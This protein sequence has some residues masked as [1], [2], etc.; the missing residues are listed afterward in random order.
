MSEEYIRLP[1]T[2][3]T[4]LIKGREEYVSKKD[5]IIFLYKC[6]SESTSLV[7]KQT[8]EVLAKDFE[9]ER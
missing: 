9:K 4:Y 3:I 7:A 1:R 2:K 8:F 6:A 5:L